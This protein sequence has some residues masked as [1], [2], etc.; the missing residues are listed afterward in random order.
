MSESSPLP[1]IEDGEA[2]WHDY[3]VNWFIN[4]VYA[5]SPI[6]AARE[7]YHSMARYGALHFTVRAVSRNSNGEY[8]EGEWM[9]VDLDEEG[10]D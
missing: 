9:S 5:R 10:I 2:E 1:D 3:E 8:E 6:E 4:G 7:A